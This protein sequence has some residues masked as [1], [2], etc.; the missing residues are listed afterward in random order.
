MLDGVAAMTRFLNLISSEPDISKVP[1][2]IDSSNFSVSQFYYVYLIYQSFEQPLLLVCKQGTCHTFLT[3]YFR[4]YDF[5]IYCWFGVTSIL[6][7]VFILIFF[8]FISNFHYD[9]QLYSQAQVYIWSNNPI[10]ALKSSSTCICTRLNKI[11]FDDRSK[12]ST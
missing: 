5:K 10:Q 8:V 3:L 11:K 12:H 2:C 9:I 7:F 4:D 1:I 6:H